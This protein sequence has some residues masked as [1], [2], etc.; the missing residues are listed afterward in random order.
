MATFKR[1]PLPWTTVAAA[2]T[3]TVGWPASGWRPAAE[4][5]ECRGIAELRAITGTGELNVAL[6]IQVANVENAPTD[7]TAAGELIVGF[8]TGQSVVYPSA[9]VD[10]SSVT[11]ANQIYRFVWYTKLTTGTA[12]TL[13]RVG[14][15]VEMV[16]CE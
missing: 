4:L 1:I 10:L 8:Q 13:G 14:G 5:K 12:M 7:K 15:V 3:S 2:S 16:E 6:G 11:S 9:L